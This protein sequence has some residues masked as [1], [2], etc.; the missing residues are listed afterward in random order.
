MML[1]FPICSSYFPF[2]DTKSIPL[3]TPSKARRRKLSDE[4]AAI[5]EKIRVPDPMS[6]SESSE[7]EEDEK[8]KTKTGNGKSL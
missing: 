4:E 5:P 3:R 8:E 6:S 2:F 7:K 1:N